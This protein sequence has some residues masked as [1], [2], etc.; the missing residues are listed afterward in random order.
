M[1]AHDDWPPGEGPPDDYE[2]T[3]PTRLPVADKNAEQAALAALIKNPAIAGDL[4]T[5]IDGTDFYWTTHETIWDTWHKLTTDNG[6]TAP[7]V[8]L[9]NARL[10]ELKDIAAIRALAD[11]LTTDTQPTLATHYAQ[12]IRDHARL[13]TVHDLAAGLEQLAQKRNV[14]QVEAYLGEALQRLDDT[15]TRFGPRPAAATGFHDLA[16]IL[17][18]EPP[19]QAP[20]A[21]VLRT[22]GHALFYN[23]KVNGVFGDPES[24]KTWLAQAAVVEALNAGGTAAMIDVDH[25]GPDHTAAR[26]L[27]LGARPAAIADPDRFRYYEPEEADE[28]LAAVDD[29]TRRR[30][31]VYLLDSLG[32]VLPMLG[33]K[34]IDNDE[35]TAALRRTCTP[36]AVAG[37]CVITIDHLPKSTEAR[38]TGYAIGGTAKKRIMRGSYLRT[39]V[40]TQPAPGQVGRITLRIEKDTIGELRKVTPGGYAGTLILDSTQPHVTTW[41]VERDEIPTGPDGQLRPTHLMEAVSRHVEQHDQCTFRDIKESITSKD[42]WLRLAIRHLID[43]GFL[44]T[45]PGPRNSTLHHAIS[46]YREAEDDQI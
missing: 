34:S 21:Y 32:E 10:I 23:G 43:E 42:K 44:S 27:L 31:D 26:L 11:I 40:R 22:D 46:L 9:L 18:G 41:S 12:L 3:P 5:Q 14:D 33:V 45:L 4:V 1:T 24:G 13:R 7:D 29:I 35:I 25:N 6:G 2:P 20:P 28:L 8:V 30:P 16:W 17:T 37:C 39:E 19:V 38:G 15:V 36:P